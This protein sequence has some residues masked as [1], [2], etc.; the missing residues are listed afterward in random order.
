MQQ[1][2]PL[3]LSPESHLARSAPDHP[4]LYFSPRV[5]HEVARRFSQG[6]PGLVTYAVKANPHPAVLSNL[7][8]AGITAFDV[9]SPAEMEAVRAASPDAVM[10]YNNP[11][12]SEAEIAAGIEHGVASWSVDELSELEKLDAVPRACEIAVRFALPVAG[13]AYDFGSKFGAAPEEAVELLKQV[14]AKGWTPALCFHP[15]T[16]CEDEMAWVE[17]VHAAKRIVDAAG[18]RI[19]RLNVGGGFAANR[20][21]VA[22]DL[23]KVFAAI[24]TAADQAFGVEK[25]TLICEPGRAMVSE[26][27]TLAARIKGMRKDGA[28]VFL[29]DGIYGGLVDIRDMGL[30][31]RVE[32]VASDGTHRSGVRK[33]R[34]VFGPTCDS[35]DR[36]PDGLPLPCDCTAGDYVLFPGLGAYSSAMSTQF[37]GYGLSDVATVIELAG[38]AAR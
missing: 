22:P 12:R 10:H 32:V 19:A 14:A 6:F 38:Q 33:P 34:V 37:N 28:V 35:L 25:P 29:N 7:V 2:P 21:G 5:L 8:A 20:D 15:G 27:F 13:A 36:L 17:Y 18:V 16:Q 11:M 26:S 24:G 23:E 30:P 1:I 4:I 31:G 3:W 9:A